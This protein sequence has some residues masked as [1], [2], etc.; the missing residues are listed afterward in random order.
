M[1]GSDVVRAEDALK[2]V[3]DLWELGIKSIKSPGPGEGSCLQGC[4]RSLLW[5]TEVKSAVDTSVRGGHCI[6]VQS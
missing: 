5:Q 4:E 1:E 6:R 3:I 2:P